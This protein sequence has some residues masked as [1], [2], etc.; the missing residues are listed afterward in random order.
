MASTVVGCTQCSNRRH[1]LTCFY[2]MTEGTY[3]STM[4]QSILHYPLNRNYSTHEALQAGQQT[5][6]GCIAEQDNSILS[7]SYNIILLQVFCQLASSG[8]K[9]RRPKDFQP[10]LKSFYNFFPFRLHSARPSM[11]MVHNAASIGCKSGWVYELNNSMM[12]PSS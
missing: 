9:D 1:A 6:F 8:R 3:L 4:W 2:V 11:T 5:T 10:R 7:Y 12:S